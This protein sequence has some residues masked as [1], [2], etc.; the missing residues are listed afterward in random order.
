MVNTFLGLSPRCCGT[1]NNDMEYSTEYQ[2]ALVLPIVL[3]LFWWTASKKF[4]KLLE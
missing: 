2:A 4:Y 1:P 3:F